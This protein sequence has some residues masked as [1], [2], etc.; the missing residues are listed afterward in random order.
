MARITTTLRLTTQDDTDFLGRILAKYARAGDCFLLRGQIGAGKS[1]LARSFIRT[2]L[3]PDTEVPS[4]TFTLVQTYNYNNLEIWH[5]DLYR[6]SDAQEA[7]ELGLTDAF[8]EHICLIEWP[9]LLGGLAPTSALDIEMSVAPDCHLAT[10]TF[11]DNWR[12]RKGEDARDARD[13]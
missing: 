1:T 5:A 9:E 2:L 12:L 8:S 4:P 6:L 3:G 10:L 11:D 13:A 7:V